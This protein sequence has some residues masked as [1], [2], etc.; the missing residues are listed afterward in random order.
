MFIDD[1]II[2]SKK[3]SPEIAKLKEQLNREY[4]ITEL[5]LG[6]YFLGM[7]ITRNRKKGLLWLD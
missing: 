6:T 2:Y 3:G 1:Y 4:N 7:R 5:G